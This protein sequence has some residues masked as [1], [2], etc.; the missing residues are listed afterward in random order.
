MSIRVNDRLSPCGKS[1]ID[2]VG[3]SK[4][5]LSL[6]K[7]HLR[8]LSGSGDALHGAIVE[9]NIELANHVF[10]TCGIQVPNHVLVVPTGAATLEW[11]IDDKTRRRL[12][13]GREVAI[14]PAGLFVAPRWDANVDLI[15]LAIA[16]SYLN[17]LV[18]A[19]DDGGQ[20]IELVPHFHVRDP[21]LV[22]VAHEQL[23]LREIW[24]IRIR[25][26]LAAN[27]REL[28]MF[29]LGDRQQAARVRS[30]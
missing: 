19:D 8:L 25:L 10:D 22:A 9:R 20:R 14:N 30:H 13:S 6:I 28:A 16:P 3:A 7:P 29:N 17:G 21:L 15:L 18:K 2:A 23:K 26:Q 4:T 24:A 27:T 1:Q 12:F 11:T 5:P